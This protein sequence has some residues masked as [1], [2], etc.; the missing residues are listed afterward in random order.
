MTPSASV[1]DLLRR[2]L[3]D[4]QKALFTSELRLGLRLALSDAQKA[5]FSD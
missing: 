4:A 3:S 2:A 5:L 1:E